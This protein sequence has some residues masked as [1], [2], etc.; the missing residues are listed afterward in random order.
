MKFI[1]RKEELSKLDKVIN[2]DEMNFTLDCYKY[3]FFSRSG[4]RCEKR[5]DVVLI[6][7]EEIFA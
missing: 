5:D 2:S 4:F 6:A 3:V 7:L 1:G